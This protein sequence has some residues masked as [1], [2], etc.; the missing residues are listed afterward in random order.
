[1]HIV[2][3]THEYPKK[4]LNTGG[5]GYFVQFLARNIVKQNIRV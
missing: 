5:I 3:L 2:Y 4:G 1:M